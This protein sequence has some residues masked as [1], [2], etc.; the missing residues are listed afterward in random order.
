MLA[1]G[2]MDEFCTKGNDHVTY[3]ELG[4]KSRNKDFSTSTPNSI[5]STY[6]SRRGHTGQPFSSLSFF[7]KVKEE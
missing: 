2:L 4:R 3:S 6:A 5:N 7:K 1:L